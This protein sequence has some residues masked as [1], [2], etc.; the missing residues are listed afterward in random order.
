M[1]SPK[2]FRF[3]CFH[4]LKPR[5]ANWWATGPEYIAKGRPYWNC[6]N[7]CWTPW[8]DMFSKLT[9]KR[10]YPDILWLQ[11]VPKIGKEEH[12]FH[13]F[14]GHQ[15]SRLYHI[16]MGLVPR[17]AVK[18]SLAVALEKRVPLI[19]T[20]CHLFSVA[21]ERKN[22]VKSWISIKTEEQP[23]A[24]SLDHWLIRVL[25]GTIKISL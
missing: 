16:E 4:A 18:V 2:F 20:D 14:R 24:Q 1:D 6:W 21:F 9:T 8:N 5:I 15:D 17:V 19:K 11:R 12:P 25:G 7:D 13:Q 22:G 3:W 23:S 10:I